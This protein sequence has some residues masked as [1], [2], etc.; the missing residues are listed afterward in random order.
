MK[1]LL[2]TF[3]ERDLQNATETKWTTDKKVLFGETDLSVEF[4]ETNGYGM[5]SLNYGRG[6]IS[7]SEI[8]LPYCA[9]A[10]TVTSHT[11]EGPFNNGVFHSTDSGKTWRMERISSFNTWVP[12]ICK[13]KGYCYYFGCQ[14]NFWFSRKSAEDGK[15]DTPKEMTKTFTLSNWRGSYIALAQEDMVHACWMDRRHDMRRF[16][17]D[18]PPVE[19]DDIVYCHRKDSDGGWSKDVILSEGLLYSYW[20]SMSVEG[21]NV[22]VAWSG[23]SSAGKHHTAYSPNDIYYVTSKDG[24]NTWSTPLKVT[25]KAKDGVVSGK[26]QVMLLNGVI[27]LFYIQGTF[28]KPEQLSRV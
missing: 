17:I 15:W 7:D 13:T 20:P 28:G 11:E 26:P 22:A 5:G 10:V 3:A 19:N 14:Y 27:H 8:Y 25:D 18:G 23:I 16:N 9:S 4:G 2:G 24:G 21:N 1:A 12:V 6:V